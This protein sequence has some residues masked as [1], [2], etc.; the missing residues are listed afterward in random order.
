MLTKAL[1]AIALLAA[2]SASAEAGATI[3]DKRYWPNEAKRSSP[4]ST[5]LQTNPYSAFA[6]YRGLSRPAPTSFGG[7]L[8]PRYYGGPKGR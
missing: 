7:G 5:A 1:L 3:S 6:Y 2:L 8:G 4:D